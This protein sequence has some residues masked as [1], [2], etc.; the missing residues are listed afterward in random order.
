MSINRRQLLLAACTLPWAPAILSSP[1]RQRVVIVGGGWGGLAAAKQLSSFGEAF[2]VVLLES[3]THFFSQPLANRW[4]TGQDDGRHL[5]H[6]LA[7][8]A[9][10]LGYRF[11]N[12]LVNA[13]DRSQ[14]QVHSSAGK[15][16]YDWLILA[17][18]IGENWAALAVDDER[19]AAQAFSSAF[20]SGGTLAGLQQRIN[21]FSGGHCLLSI[22]PQPYRCPP[23]PYERALMLAGLFKS[24]GLKFHLTLV[25][26]NAPWPAYQRVFRE[27][28]HEQITYLPQTR[29]R[30]LNSA[31]RVAQLDF[32][33]LTFDQAILMPPQQ[34]GA[35]CWQAGLIRQQPDGRA[36]GWADVHPENFQAIADP[37]V[38]VIGDSVGPV[39]PLFGHYPK[40]GQIAACMGRIVA[41]EIEA[42]QRGKSI[43]PDLPESTCYTQVNV[44]PRETIR[45]ES[46]YTRR[47]DGPL[48]QQIK[49]VRNNFPAGE[50]DAW[51]ASMHQ[52]LFG[53]N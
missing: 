45:I 21:N 51:L 47:A 14:R 42:R 36:S 32:D 18:G 19:A 41:K 7:P 5:Q 20:S 30:Q 15:F 6:A 49:Q 43:Q 31:Q 10:A 46:R 11:E 35:I 25:E 13:V 17:P 12:A 39:S 50:A 27:H 34:A 1:A 23:A 4:L 44:Y 24:R 3:N 38:F 33:A 48:V 2:E 8:V 37:R 28:F 53:K 52:E 22:P 16:D 26:P 29:L 9:Q 40:T